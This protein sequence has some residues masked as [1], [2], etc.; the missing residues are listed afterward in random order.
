MTNIMHMRDEIGA[1]CAQGDLYIM[2]VA[3]LPKTATE[4]MPQDGNRH[5][6]AHSETGHHHVADC[7]TMEAAR[8][9]ASP[10]GMDIIHALVKEPT[11]LEHLRNFHTHA[12]IMLPPG[13]YVM[14]TQREA[15]PEGWQRAA[16]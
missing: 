3:D 12:P 10:P 2:R 6:L 8:V 16:D 15:M 5:I 7:A 1:T 11:K 9:K 4:P 14:R 13:R